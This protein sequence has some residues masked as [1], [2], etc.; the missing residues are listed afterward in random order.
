MRDHNKNRLAALDDRLCDGAIG[1]LSRPL[2]KSAAGLL[3]LLAAA[4]G[5]ACARLLGGAAMAESLLCGGVFTLW[6]AALFARA[7]V[8]VM[9]ALFGGAAL[10]ALFA[11]RMAALPIVSPDCQDYLIPWARTMAGMGFSE[12]MT[13][14]VGDYTVLYQYFVFLLSRLPL[15]PVVCYKLLSIGFEA[16]LAYSCASLTCLCCGKEKGSLRF[17]AVFFAVL[18]APTVFLN[19]AVWSQCDAVYASLALLG[20]LL[21]LRERPHA[22][23]AALAVSLC[24]KLQAVFIL[25]VCAMLLLARRLSLRHALTALLTMGAVSLPALLAGKGVK[26]VLGVYLYQMGEY[27]QLVLDAPT[28]YQFLPAGGLI[29]DGTAS[30]IGIMLAAGAMCAALVLGL[31]RGGKAATPVVDV[32]FALCICIPFLL[33]HMHERYFF[34]ADILSIAY[35]AVHPRRA[36]AP[37]V[38]LLC[39]LNGY[40]AYLFSAP[41]MGWTVP[42]L[43]MMALCA[44]TLALLGRD[45]VKGEVSSA[46]AVDAEGAAK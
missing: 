2:G 18:A 29:P 31:R 38:V 9:D 23:C 8:R 36:Y 13:G 14:R 1:A 11:A 19:G 24:L 28:M 4:L 40:C 39:S 34:L 26:G 3:Y 22:G 37:A 20:V 42:A 6:C 16:L 35:A 21:I 5:A 44:A 17:C 15:D 43:A 32:C 33:P 10:V 41:L 27:K 30:M 12:V 46:F 7:R 25:P 45:A